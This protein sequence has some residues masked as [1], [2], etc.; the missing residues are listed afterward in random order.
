MNFSQKCLQH[1][2]QYYL[3]KNSLAIQNLIGLSCPP[4]NSQLGIPHNSPLSC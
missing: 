2:G 1:E 4:R 3:N